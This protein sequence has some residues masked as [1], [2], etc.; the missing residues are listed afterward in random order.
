MVISTSASLTAQTLNQVLGCELTPS[1]WKTCS[2]QLQFITPQ[3]G[4]FWDSRDTKSGLYIVLAGKVRLLNDR[5]ELVSTLTLGEAF[6][7]LTFLSGRAF[8]PYCMRAGMGVEL[9]FVP[10]Q[11][12]T[13][14]MQKH[15]NI[16]NFLL[17]V[18]QTRNLLL[19]NAVSDS[20]SPTAQRLLKSVE[21]LPRQKSTPAQTEK[22]RRSYFPM[23]TQQAQHLWQR[24]IQRYP[25]FAQQSASDCGAACLDIFKI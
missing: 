10:A 2:A 7:E 22:K 4:K 12:L 15:R 8:V 17:K 25:F 19:Q 20:K 11:L 1:E 3:V 6:G 14:L 16:Q 5:D 21:P 24:V 23:P 18:A 13:D 9:C